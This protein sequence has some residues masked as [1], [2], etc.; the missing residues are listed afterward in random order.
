M[1]NNNI[2]KQTMTKT[3]QIITILCTTIF[4]ACGNRQASPNFKDEKIFDA[5][6]IKIPAV[7]TKQNEG[8]WLYNSDQ[9]H[10]LLLIE[11]NTI[12][13]EGKSISIHLDNFINEIKAKD[14]DGNKVL[15]KKD[16]FKLNNIKGA[17]AYFEQD[18][19]TGAFPVMTYYVVSILQDGDDIIK[20]NAVTTDK[21]DIK[22]IETTIHSI[23]KIS[24]D[25]TKNI[26]VVHPR[27]ELNIEKIKQEGYKVFEKEN[28]AIKC[29]AE[30]KLNTDLVKQ[31]KA[32]GN[33]LPI[34]S[35]QG[36]INPNNPNTAVMYG[37][38][39]IDLSIEYNKL[40]VSKHNQYT[41]DYLKYY[42]ENYAN[43]VGASYTYA[44]DKFN[45]VDYCYMQTTQP[46]PFKAMFFINDKK[47][48]T[49]MVGS[50]NELDKKYNEFKNSFKFLK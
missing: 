1:I 34:Y 43:R 45:S 16:T 22:N 14:P 48:Y 42:A 17:S 49:I 32:Q 41:I 21:G 46:F 44:K 4:L 18:N 2:K 28:F 15:I 7:T 39:I 20:I 29:P 6:S 13:A 19:S 36:A 38:D 11:T 5:Y 8:V 31:Q 50:N 37:I 24:P 10:E 23:S 26:S 35:Y 25:S 30:L 33:P 47:I 3:R 40:P 12:K 9:D 27:E